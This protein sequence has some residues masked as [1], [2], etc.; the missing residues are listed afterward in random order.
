MS[1]SLPLTSLLV[2]LQ[3]NHAGKITSEEKSDCHL[4]LS[5]F[6]FTKR[7]LSL[8]LLSAIRLVSAAYLRLLMFLLPILIPACAK[9]TL[10]VFYKWNNRVWMSAYLFAMWLT[11]TALLTKLTLLDLLLRKKDFF[12]N[13]SSH[14]QCYWSSKSSDG[15]VQW[16]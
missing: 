16:D 12:R 1:S 2:I 13:I 5:S 15:D 6:T 14:W 9:S 8:F 7:L 11:D 4:S 3:V 10:P